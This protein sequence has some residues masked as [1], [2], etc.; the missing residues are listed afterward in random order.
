MSLL[1]DFLGSSTIPDRHKIIFNEI[2]KFVVRCV[3]EKA[4]GNITI[5][6]YYCLA[7][8]EGAIFSASDWCV[9]V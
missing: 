7:P 6:C 5:K 1:P 9:W 4:A 3:V 8:R 2:T